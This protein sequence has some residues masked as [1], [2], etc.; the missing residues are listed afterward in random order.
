MVYNFFGSRSI[1]R[2]GNSPPN[3]I[4]CEDSSLPHNS[5]PNTIHCRDNSA[6]KQFTAKTINRVD[7]SPWN[8][9][10]RDN[11]PWNN[12]LQRQFTAETIYRGDNSPRRQFTA[13]NKTNSLPLS[14]LFL[15]KIQ[16]LQL[17]YIVIILKLT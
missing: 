11:S 15:L 2:G 9:S 10:L 1:H 13:T 14:F 6:R 17:L 4:H 3:T 5:P 12:S 7:N 8:N 16:R